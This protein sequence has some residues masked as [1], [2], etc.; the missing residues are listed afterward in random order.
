MALMIGK[1]TVLS[2]SATT[3]LTAVAQVVDISHS[4]AESETYDSTTLDGGVGKTYSQTGYSEGG[5]VD[6]S[7]FLDSALAGHQLIGDQITTPADTYYGLKLADGTT[8]TSTFT[9]AGLGHGFDVA[10]NDGVKGSVSVKLTGLY[11]YQT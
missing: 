10:M 8:N 7:L 9:G 4:G 3:T 5:S 6:F 2:M 1:G 11:E